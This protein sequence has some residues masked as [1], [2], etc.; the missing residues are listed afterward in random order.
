MLPKFHSPLSVLLLADPVTCK[1][2]HWNR[3]VQ[4]AACSLPQAPRFHLINTLLFLQLHF[5]LSLL[6]QHSTLIM[7]QGSVQMLHIIPVLLQSHSMSQL[8]A[9]Q[10][11]R[12]YLKALETCTVA[13]RMGLLGSTVMTSIHQW[14]LHLRTRTPQLLLQ[15]TAQLRPAPKMSPTP[16]QARSQLR[17]GAESWHG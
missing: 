1:E 2:L 11:S 15:Q 6:D 12:M 17:F 16:P 4:L 9:P 8:L 7:Q 14:I 3:H 5:S 13:T 10:R